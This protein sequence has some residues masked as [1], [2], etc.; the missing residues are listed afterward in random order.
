MPFQKCRGVPHQ[1]NW[2]KRHLSIVIAYSYILVALCNNSPT[3][4]NKLTQY[5]YL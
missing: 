2:Y 3:T 5:E 1:F 4:L